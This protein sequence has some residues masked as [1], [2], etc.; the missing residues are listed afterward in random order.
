LVG[1]PHEAG[2]MGRRPGFGAV[3][4]RFEIEWLH[5]GTGS[6]GASGFDATHASCIGA[7]AM[8]QGAAFSE[9]EG[10]PMTMRN[11]MLVLFV[12]IPASLL[13]CPLASTTATAEGGGTGGGR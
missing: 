4:P 2:G 12:L 3:A 11:V 10:G 7:A 8:V 5:S 6:C 13:G 1:V 9:R